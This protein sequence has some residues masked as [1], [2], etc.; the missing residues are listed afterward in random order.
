[1]NVE[2]RIPFRPDDRLTGMEAHSHTD[3]AC[4]EAGLRLGRR[5]DRLRCVGESDEERVSLRV[6]LGAPVSGE[7]R[8]KHAAVLPEHVGV[9][10]AVL[11]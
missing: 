6:H 8:T 4:L 7:R 5:C 3:R 11:V 9:P 2:P 1:M 10:L